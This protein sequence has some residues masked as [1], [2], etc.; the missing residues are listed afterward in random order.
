M[1]RA[2]I[3][4]LFEDNF[5]E[6][7][8]EILVLMA[9]ST[10]GAAAYYDMWAPSNDPLAYVDLSDNSLHT[11][12]IRLEWLVE[13]KGW[14]YYFNPQTAYRIRV[15][16]RKPDYMP[17]FEHCFM[18]LEVLEENVADKRFE[19]ILTEYNREVSY[20]DGDFH[21]ILDK[22]YKWFE[23]AILHGD[24]EIEFFIETEELDRLKNILAAYKKATEDFEKWL[25]TLKQFA[26]QKLTKLANEW[27]E[28]DTASI[29]EKDF[30]ERI[31]LSSINLTEEK[32]FIVYLYD[33]DM[34]FDHIICV[35]GNL[36]GTLEDADIEG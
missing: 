36:D 8:K 31:S 9:T 23:G 22:E 25:D 19:E 28:E 10:N 7:E 12:S 3:Q 29:S 15:R 21:L 32:G 33:D 17:N 11:G 26:A 30:A 14:R 20:D 16:P 34:F 35:Y 5:L 2:K 6:E 1:E 4:E 27:Q 13:G 18:L 24:E